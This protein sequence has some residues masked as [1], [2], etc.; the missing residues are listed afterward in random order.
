[1]SNNDNESMSAHTH[2]Y[3][4]ARP[5]PD[6][7]PLCS[8]HPLG[9][10]APPLNCDDDEGLLDDELLLLLCFAARLGASTDVQRCN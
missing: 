9:A 1:M 5:L 8:L 2:K 7:D 6:Q 10:E 3:T 4:L